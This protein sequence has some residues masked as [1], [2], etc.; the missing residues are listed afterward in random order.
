VT[1]AALASL[2]LF[3]LTSLLDAALLWAWT[4]AGQRMVYDLAADLFHRLQRLSLLFHGRRSVGD[5]LSRLTG[6][7]W[8]V[9]SATEGL[10]V[11]PAQHL[12]TLATLGAV[13]WRLDQHLTLMSLAAAPL[14]AG[15]SLFFGG[16]L[17]RRAAL[18]RE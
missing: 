17:K 18:Q 5:S 1:V 4:V 13:A 7:A 12:L 2:G 8:C 11:A 16:R 3:A 9:Y 10:L 6:D 15:A 14:L